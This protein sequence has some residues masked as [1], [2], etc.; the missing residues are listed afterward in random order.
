MVNARIAR[1][2]SPVKQFSVFAENRVGR[3]Y[4]LTSLLNTYDVHILALTVHDTI[5]S[6]IIRLIV[7][8]RDKTRELLI[9]NDFPYVEREV[10]VVDLPDESQLKTMLA[11]LLEAEVNLHYFYS[12]LKRPEGRERLAIHVEEPETAA[13]ALNGRGFKTLSEPDLLR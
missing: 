3:L 13:Q 2:M 4:D 12:F 7:D 11:A 8:D 9:N 6:A 1:A 5:D 10:V